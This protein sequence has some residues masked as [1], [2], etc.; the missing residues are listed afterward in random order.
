MTKIQESIEIVYLKC[1]FV[2]FVFLSCY[3]S[4]AWLAGQLVNAIKRRQP[5]LRITEG[6]ILCVSI[7]G[8]CHDLGEYYLFKNYL[9]MN[10]NPHSVFIS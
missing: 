5:E 2:L 1:F 4:V 3:F 8:L 9:S 10:T 7:A 6:D